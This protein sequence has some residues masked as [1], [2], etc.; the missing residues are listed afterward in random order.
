MGAARNRLAHVEWGSRGTMEALGRREHPGPPRRCGGELLRTEQEPVD[1]VVGVR[2]IVVEER[3]LPR[4]GLVGDVHRVVDRAVTPVALVLELARRV[5]RVVDQQI[6][7][8]DEL[9][10]LVGD[11]V[12]AARLGPAAARLTVVGEVGDRDARHSTR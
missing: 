9:E 4:A 10:H 11:E 6:D 12:V 2:G 1:L 5:L 3:E 8:V 7:A